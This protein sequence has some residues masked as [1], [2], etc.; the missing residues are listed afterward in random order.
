MM[1]AAA[2]FGNF[3]DIDLSARTN[4]VTGYLQVKA[5]D[6]DSGQFN[7]NK[8]VNIELPDK[9]QPIRGIDKNQIQI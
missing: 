1:T 8:L 6:K 5:T 2:F 9:E 3:L 4:G 7:I